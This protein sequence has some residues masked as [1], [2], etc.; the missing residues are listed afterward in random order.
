MN[1]APRRPTIVIAGTGR[2]AGLL[3]EE[4]L[5]RAPGRFQ[6]R[7]FGGDPQP[8]RIL[9]S[10]ALTGGEP[11]VDAARGAGLEAARGIIVDDQL[12]TSDPS[13][14]ALGACTNEPTPVHEQARR[15]AE[16][17]T[18]VGPNEPPSADSAAKNKIET[19][20]AEK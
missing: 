20:K 19:M 1:Q 10:A 13:I 7:M 9:L 12:R 3:V 14:Y 16:A 15:L 18:G 5:A 11:N 8:D 2:A 4:I 17:L 6:L